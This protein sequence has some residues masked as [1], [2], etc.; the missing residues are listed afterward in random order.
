[1]N[2]LPKGWTLE[3]RTGELELRDEH[4]TTKAWIPAPN[5]PMTIGEMLDPTTIKEMLDAAQQCRIN[6]AHEE[7]GDSGAVSVAEGN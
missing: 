3:R 2:S 1:M 7:H 4:G 5:T 6:P